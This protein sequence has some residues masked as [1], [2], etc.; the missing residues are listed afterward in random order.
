MTETEAGLV[1]AELARLVRKAEGPV[2][3]DRID[4][5]AVG[6]GVAVV[7]L[8]RQRSGPMLGVRQKSLFSFVES[9]RTL[10]PEE[11]AADLFMFVVQEPHNPDLIPMSADGIRWFDEI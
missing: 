9:D 10:R 11:M 4:I 1:V 7:I 8:F 3:V 6:D 5:E 2:T